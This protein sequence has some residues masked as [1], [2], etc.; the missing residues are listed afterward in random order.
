MDVSGERW[1]RPVSFIGLREPLNVVTSS[2][3]A[4]VVSVGGKN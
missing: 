1:S 2:C 4:R 3:R